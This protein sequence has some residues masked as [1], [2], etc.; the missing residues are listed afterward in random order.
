[1]GNNKMDNEKYV[2]NL[3]EEA[4]REELIFLRNELDNLD[5]DD[6]FGTQGWKYFFGID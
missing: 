2:N 3:K 6:Y 5:E 4:A 1:M